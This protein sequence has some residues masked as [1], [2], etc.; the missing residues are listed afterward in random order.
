MSSE[1]PSFKATLGEW[2]PKTGNWIACWRAT[3]DG[4]ADSTFHSNCDAKIPTLVIIKVVKNSKNLIF[5]GYSTVTWT[6]NGKFEFILLIES[7]HSCIVIIDN[8][9]LS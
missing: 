5:G 7:I 6:A 2:L 8:I 9:L 4:W 3:R 1:S